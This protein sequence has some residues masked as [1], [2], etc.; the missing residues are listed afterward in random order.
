MTK[1]LKTANYICKIIA[2]NNFDEQKAVLREIFGSNLFLTGKTVVAKSDKKSSSPE[3]KTALRALS[4]SRFCLWQ[5]LKDTKEKI[6][7]T[8][9]NSSKILEMARPVG[10]EPTNAG[11]KTQCLTTWRRP[12]PP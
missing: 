1:W 3:L 8:G 12:N 9:D 4:Q 11:T 10:L 5:K 6:V 2:G 7:K